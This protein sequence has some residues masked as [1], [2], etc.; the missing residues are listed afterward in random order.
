MDAIRI[1]PPHFACVVAMDSER[2][3]GLQGTLP[4]RRIPEDMKHFR[5]LTMG[6]RDSGR[7]NAVIMGRKTWQSIPSHMRPLFGR[8]NIVM[9]RNPRWDAAPGRNEFSRR[10]SFTPVPQPSFET[11]L[12]AATVGESIYV[13]GGGEVYAVA[14]AHPLCRAVYLTRIAN[15]YGCDTFLPRFEERFTLDSEELVDAAGLLITFER[16]RLQTQA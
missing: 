10:V 15:A 12:E 4:W 3:I 14:L 16:W 5:D 8:R 11:A 6:V 9:S 1:D 2:G 13:I 7:Q